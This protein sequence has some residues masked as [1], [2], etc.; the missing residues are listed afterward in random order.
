MHQHHKNPL[1]RR[2]RLHFFERLLQ[3]CGVEAVLLI[4]GF[5]DFRAFREQLHEHSA[6]DEAEIDVLH[7]S[8]EQRGV[9]EA[10]DAVGVAATE[11]DDAVENLVAESAQQPSNHKGR[12]KGQQ[13]AKNRP[14]SHHDERETQHP[15]AAE[16]QCVLSGEGF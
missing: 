2:Q 8:E 14:G 9:D 7:H 4:D 15:H 1:R 3:F 13:T 11:T 5:D 10:I 6:V 16:Q 12:G